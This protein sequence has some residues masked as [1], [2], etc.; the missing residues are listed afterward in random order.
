[1]KHISPQQFDS[2][3]AD[4]SQYNSATRALDAL[5]R[6]SEDDISPDLMKKWDGLQKMIDIS[7]ES[8]LG[9]AFMQGVT[10]AILSELDQMDFNIEAKHVYGKEC[11]WLRRMRR[12]ERNSNRR[13]VMY[14]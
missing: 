13:S 5:L 10:E 8:G 11:Y 1:M 7:R 2:H 12:I 9:D 4:F 14:A 6:A 3:V